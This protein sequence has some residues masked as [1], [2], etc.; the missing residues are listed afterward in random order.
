MSRLRSFRSRLILAAGFGLIGIMAAVSFFALHA[1]RNPTNFIV[2][3]IVIFGGAAVAF[4]LGGLWQIRKGL[5][6]FNQLRKSLSE[7]HDGKNNRIE[8]NYP[9]EVEPLVT[10]LNA[11]LE[12][13]D[14]SVARAF[15]RA[16]DLAHGL[17]TPLALLSREAELAN[18]AGQHELAA[19]ITQ[20]VDRMQRQM[21]YH[22]AQA[23]TAASG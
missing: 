21:N 14:K 1:F 7:V 13:R 9:A 12:H 11:L 3:H 17:K 2:S 5:S 18:A 4:V 10:D 22:L 8:G 6:E 19:A 23:R 15:A 16:G 20:Q